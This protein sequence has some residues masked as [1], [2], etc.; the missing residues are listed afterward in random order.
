MRDLKSRRLVSVGAPASRTMRML[1]APMLLVLCVAFPPLGMSDQ[2]NRQLNITIERVP[3]PPGQDTITLKATI[4]NVSKHEVIIGVQNP[5]IDYPLTVT[6][7]RG[8]P[9]LL[10][11]RGKA[12]FSKERPGSSRYVMVTLEPGE[13][14]VDTWAIDDFFEFAQP[15][16]YLITVRRDFEAA[17]EED[18]SNTLG[19]ALK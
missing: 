10:S 16:R 2:A 12:V 5:L 13:T 3:D 7:S 8:V 15:G 14:R 4:K 18:S 11:K 19:V 9:V 17:H 1:P 6:D